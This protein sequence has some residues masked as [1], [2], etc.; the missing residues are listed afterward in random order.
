MSRTHLNHGRVKVGDLRELGRQ[1]LL[2]ILDSI[3]GTKVLVWDECLTGPLGL[4]AEYSVLKEHDVVKMFPM[5]ASGLPAVRADNVVFIVRPTV[6]NCDVIA[7]NIRAEETK[8]GSGLKTEYHS[9]FVPKKSLFC[10]KRLKEGGVFGSLTIYELAIYLYPLD[11]DLLSM[12]LPDTF[13]EVCLE[14]DPTS[15]HY[16]AKALT[17]LQIICGTIP[18]IYGKGSSAVQLFDLMV[19]MRK[20]MAGLES[21]VKPQID[22]IVILDRSVDLLST[23]PTQLTYEGLIDELFGISQGSVKLPAHKFT[24]QGTDST[25]EMKVIRLNS[26][27]ELFHEIRGINFN[28]VGPT[29]SRKAR[30]IS[31]QLQERHDAKTV[32]EMK[33][34]VERLPTMQAAKQSL[35]TH[36]SIAEL[37]K[38]RV[39]GEQFLETLEIEQEILSYVNSDRYLE[40]VEDLACKQ[41]PYLKL[42]RL[43]AM[44]SLVSSGLKP[45]LLDMY[46]KLVLQAYGYEH[47]LTLDNMEKAG[48]ITLN[49]G[50]KTF[51]TLRKRLNLISDVVDE[52]NPTD[53]AYVHSVYAP[54]LVRL[55]QQLEKP[56]WRNIREVL[57]MLP[58][59]SFEDTQQIPAQLKN[60][61]RSG[62]QN[63]VILVMF[64][65][66]CTM[67]EVAALRFL[68][69]Q[70]DS[71][72]EYLIV[73]TNITTGSS[74]IESLATPL[75]A[76]VF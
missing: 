58:G 50:Q 33:E 39:V 72:V 2:D 4:I 10:E 32:R 45:K 24:V 75:Q 68:A 42:L 19:R 65:G 29:L 60:L 26:S 47:L 31:A 73:T 11:S 54:L 51:G 20:E 49:T 59:P 15:L 69:S 16:A 48:L 41:F 27:E 63:K 57:D 25:D 61:S 23:L 34:F 55:V 30:T 6:E 5:S 70:E 9:L 14:G 71:S 22:S 37:V 13:R 18:R 7:A 8:G 36:T 62:D 1:Q 53:I 46:K 40:A 76:P 35:G 56:G 44:Q 67:A 12:E 3:A 38:E 28:A 43:I 52:Q 17:Q 66:G 21:S 64:V 74:F